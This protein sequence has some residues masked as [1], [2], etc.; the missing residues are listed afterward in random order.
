MEK[1]IY[2]KLVQVEQSLSKIALDSF[3]REMPDSTPIAPPLGYQK[4]PSMVDHIRALVARGLDTQAR[5]AGLETF[6]EANDFEVGDDYE[7]ETPYEQL[8]AEGELGPLPPEVANWSAAER[9]AFISSRVAAAQAAAPKDNNPSV[10]GGGAG[11]SPEPA[12]A[13]PAPGQSPS[14]RPASSPATA[15]AGK[16]G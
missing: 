5:A 6:E 1:Q 12:P 16:P 13:P 14:E 4:Q 10:G 9:D 11:A 7:P 3:G 8:G 2:D 15:P